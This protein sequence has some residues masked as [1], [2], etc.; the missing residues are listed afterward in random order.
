MEVTV[1][2][3]QKLAELE[4]KLRKLTY[5]SMCVS[6]LTRMQPDHRKI[7]VQQT[8]FGLAADGINV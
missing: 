8:A 6:L 2:I 3:G 7:D 1:P 4:K 5:G